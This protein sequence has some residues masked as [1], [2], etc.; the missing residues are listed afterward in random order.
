MREE[1]ESEKSV[2][3]QRWARRERQLQSGAMQLLGIGGDFQGLAQLE[4]LALELEHSD[5]TGKGT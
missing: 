4:G 2:T 5:A 3:V 1:L